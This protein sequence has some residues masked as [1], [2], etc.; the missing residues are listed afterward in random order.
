MR[1]VLLLFGLGLVDGHGPFF[2][3]SI[4][5]IRVFSSDLAQACGWSRVGG[6]GRLNFAAGYAY[7]YICICMCVSILICTFVYVSLFIRVC[8][9]IYICTYICTYLPSI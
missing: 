6:G 2:L 8:I 3:A 7:I 9:C 5:Q 4:V 1:V